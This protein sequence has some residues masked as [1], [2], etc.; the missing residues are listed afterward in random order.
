MDFTQEEAAVAAADGWIDKLFECKPLTENEVRQLC[1]KV[2]EPRHGD[3]DP[4]LGC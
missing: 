4:P 1:E 3:E 2:R